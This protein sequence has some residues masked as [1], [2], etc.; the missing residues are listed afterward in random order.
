MLGGRAV[1]RGRRGEVEGEGKGKARGRRWGEQ[2]GRGVG[3][4][5]IDV[6]P[7]KRKQ[8]GPHGASNWDFMR[9]A[10]PPRQLILPC[11]SPCPS[12]SLRQSS[13]I[14]LMAPPTWTT[15]DQ[16]AF[17][18]QEDSKWEYVKSGETTLKSFY[19]RTTNAFLEKWP[20]APDAKTLKAA[21]GDVVKAQEM[22]EAQVHNVSDLYVLCRRRL[23]PRCSVSQTGLATVTAKRNNPQ[24]F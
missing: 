18:S 6:W 15:K 17:L 8:T 9:H 16:L 5:M 14:F 24:E 21:D 13:S 20:T 12:S 1:G 11:A 4:S 3:R 2:H 7:K 10:A 19:L 22:A 23:T